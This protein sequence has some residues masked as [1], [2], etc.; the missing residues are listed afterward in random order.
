MENVIVSVNI[1]DF[2]GIFDSISDVV[3]FLE[4][5]E[6]V[7]DIVVFM[8]KLG[9][10]S[11]NIIAS[12]GEYLNWIGYDGKA[13]FLLDESDREKIPFDFLNEINLNY[14]IYSKSDA[15]C[16]GDIEFSYFSKDDFQRDEMDEYVL[17]LYDKSKNKEGKIHCM[18]V[19]TSDDIALINSISCD[20]VCLDNGS[21]RSFLPLD[22]KDVVHKISD[23]ELN[24][25]KNSFD[26][27]YNMYDKESSILKN[28][29][30]LSREFKSIKGSIK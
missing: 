11:A 28:G 9:K 15:L 20:F 2:N 22:N 8:P 5:N 7:S 29:K 3:E 30:V 13:F 6:N 26:A 18:A 19:A 14:K 16:I 10:S 27:S 24:H 12:F 1:M 25:L 21:I 17:D 23:D 4:L